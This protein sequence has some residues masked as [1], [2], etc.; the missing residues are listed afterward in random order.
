MRV[1]SQNKPAPRLLTSVA[2][3]IRP[4]QLPQ[5]AGAGSLHNSVPPASGNGRAILVGLT[6]GALLICGVG[7][8]Y[9]RKQGARRHAEEERKLVAVSTRSISPPE[10]LIKISAISLG[11]PRLAIINGRQF[12]EGEEI[13]IH[14][15]PANLAVTLRVLKISDGRIDLSDGRQVITVRLEVPP[16][17]HRPK[18]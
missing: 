11:Q 5:G 15:P 13:T 7:L 14:P 6:V 9:K 1:V 12:G 8:L 17:S 4:E 18:P 10:P 3:E 16:P 2:P